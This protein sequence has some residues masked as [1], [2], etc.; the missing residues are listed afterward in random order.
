LAPWLVYLSGMLAGRAEGSFGIDRLLVPVYWFYWFIEPLG[1]GLWYSL[2]AHF[3][4]FLWSGP[5][6]L[7][8][9]LY[10]SAILLGVVLFSMIAA[11]WRREQWPRLLIG[12]QDPTA[13][14]TN[15][16][17]LGCGLLMTISMLTIHRPYMNV[18]FPLEFVWLAYMVVGADVG[19]HVKRAARLALLGLW[20]VEL[21]VSVSFLR[22]IHAH[23]GAPGAEYGIAYSAKPPGQTFSP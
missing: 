11:R 19:R 14:T 17:F 20:V 1:V 23:G 8:G 12:R 21:F 4:E 7:V 18:T 3:P 13:F 6:H 22:Y 10:V 5:G 16:V 15:A 9:V 2:G